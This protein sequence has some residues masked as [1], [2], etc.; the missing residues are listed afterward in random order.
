MQLRL[1]R[2]AKDVMIDR[3]KKILTNHPIFAKYSQVVLDIRKSFSDRKISSMGAELAYYSMVAFFTLGV[4]VVYASTLLPAVSSGAIFAIENL[5]PESVSA[6]MVLIISEISIPN[7]VIPLF[8][9]IVMSVWFS[10]RAIRSMSVSFDTIFKV[11][12]K[13]KSFQRTYHSIIF[14]LVFELLFISIF[15][16]I[17]LGKTISINILDPLNIAREARVIFHYIRVIFP[18]VLML[19]AFWIFYH[20]LTNI[21]QKFKAAFPGALFTSVLWFGISKIFSLYFNKLSNFPVVLGSVG[22]I[23]VFLIWIYWCSIIIV[24]GAVLNYRFMILKQMRIS[25]PDKSH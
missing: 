7:K 2:K 12:H 25:A 5:L 24:V 3:V 20:S 11:K 14:T 23:F 1:K 18:I 4:G 22:G 17:V 10:S 9:T 6:M 16:F 19:L 8:I 21:K 13:K 15:T